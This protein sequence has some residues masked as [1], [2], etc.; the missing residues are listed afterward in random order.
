GPI[1]G[2]AS[3][4]AGCMSGFFVLLLNGGDTVIHAVMLC[5]NFIL[6]AFDDFVAAFF[7]CSPL[8]IV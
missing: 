5:G 1:P 3:K 4:E 8:G 7:I 6:L 2:G